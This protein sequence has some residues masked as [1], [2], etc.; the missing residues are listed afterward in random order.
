ME[1]RPPSRIWRLWI[2]PLPSGAMRLSAGTRQS[3]KTTSEVSLAR[4]P[5]LFSL[6]PGQ[7][8]AVPFSTIRAEIPCGPFEAS[9]TAMATHTSAWPPLVVNVFAPFSTQPP[10]RRSALVRVPPASEPASGSV[11]AQQPSFS[12][13][14]SGT[15]YR[16]LCSSP[17]KR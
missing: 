6:L 16:R 2:K 9:V 10:S 7:K 3:A 14:A 12:P 13:R 17:P 4:M 11:S 8:P 5:S 1:I 15:T